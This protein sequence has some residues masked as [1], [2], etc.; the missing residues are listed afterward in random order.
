LDETK[1]CNDAFT[2]EIL[3]H[4]FFLFCATL[5]DYREEHT[6]LPRLNE[7]IAYMGIDCVDMHWQQERHGANAGQT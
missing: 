6:G 3:P 5:I 2:V 7:D 1:L 4:L